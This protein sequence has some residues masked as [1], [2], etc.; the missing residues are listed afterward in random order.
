MR[1][2]LVWA[3]AKSGVQHTRDV[4]NYCIGTTLDL[5]EVGVTIIS[6]Q[7]GFIFSPYQGLFHPQAVG[8]ISIPQYWDHGSVVNE[9]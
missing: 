3:S 8:K 4:V 1:V 7:E 2:G 6:H 5:S 9:L